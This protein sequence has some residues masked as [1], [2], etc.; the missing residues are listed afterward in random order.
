ML[1]H[2]LRLRP[3]TQSV[4]KHGFPRRAW[5]PGNAER[6]KRRGETPPR[7]DLFRQQ[8]AVGPVGG[9]RMGSFFRKV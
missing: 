5:E 2:N 3:P 1:K 4:G 6:G 9:D 8:V 7:R